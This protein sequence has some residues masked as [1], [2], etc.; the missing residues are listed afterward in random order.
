M[1][2]ETPTLH[3][4]SPLPDLKSQ[5][6]CLISSSQALAVP[7]APAISRHVQRWARMLP[8]ELTGTTPRFCL[9]PG[10]AASR[11][12]TGAEADRPQTSGQVPAGCR[13][14]HSLYYLALC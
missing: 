5:F 3:A 7:N 11:P 6:A 14:R 9:E 10:L 13:W 8:V 1:Q 2:P 4:S 12:D